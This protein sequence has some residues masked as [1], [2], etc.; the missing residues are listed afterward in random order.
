MTFKKFIESRS[1]SN[2]EIAAALSISDRALYYYMS[3]NRIPEKELM[4]RIYNYT[5]HKVCPKD[6][7]NFG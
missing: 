2:K 1:V 7:Y 3:G 5:K 6:W 4:L